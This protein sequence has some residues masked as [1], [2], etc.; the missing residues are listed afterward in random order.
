MEDYKNKRL[1]TV[2]VYNKVV[3]MEEIINGDSKKDRGR[4]QA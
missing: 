2:F 1:V 3:D 4:K